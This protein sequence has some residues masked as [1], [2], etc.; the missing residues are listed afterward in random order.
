MEVLMKNEKIDVLKQIST[1]VQP[2]TTGII[3]I[4]TPA[5][6]NSTKSKPNDRP[7]PL[8]VKPRVANIEWPDPREPKGAA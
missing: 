2:H 8:A 1:A 3:L 5:L 6:K 4:K 7:S